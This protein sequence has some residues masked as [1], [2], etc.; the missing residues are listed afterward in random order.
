M[1]DELSFVNTMEKNF[2][3]FQKNVSIPSMDEKKLHTWK[4]QLRVISE[5]QVNMRCK[6]LQKRSTGKTIE[7]SK[8][9]QHIATE[10]Y[11]F[12]E[13]NTCIFQMSLKYIKLGI[14]KILFILVSC[15]FN[16]YFKLCYPSTNI[17]FFDPQQKLF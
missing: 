2:K 1:C 7:C 8:D 17:N 4:F 5:M 14:P 13:L 16:F 11:I 12:S 9:L 15:N 3:T 10:K 6:L